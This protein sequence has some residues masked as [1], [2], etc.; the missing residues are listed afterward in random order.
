MKINGWV[1]MRNTI[2]LKLNSHFLT[3]LKI[4]I[5]IM[6]KLFLKSAF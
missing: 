2:D 1:R 4:I 3:G 6:I 5:G